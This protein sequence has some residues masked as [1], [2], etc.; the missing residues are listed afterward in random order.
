M[1]EDEEYDSLLH[2][3]TFSGPALRRWQREALDSWEDNS[4]RGVVE[5]ITGTGKSLVGVAAI[6]KTVVISGGK[7]LLVVPTRAL[8]EQ[9]S[10][11][12][13]R[14]LPTIRVG[15]LTSGFADSFAS[16]DVLIAT[17]QTACKAPPIP[18]SLGLLI[19]DEVHRY[20]SEQF[21]KVMHPR[22]QRRLGLTGT[23]ERQLDDGVE[24]YLLPYFEAV[25][26]SYGYG[27]ALSEGVVARF[28]LALVAAE[29]D[30]SEQRQYTDATERC[31]DAMK[32]LVDRY[33]YPSDWPQFFA[34]VTQQLKQE[35]CRDEE[36]DLCSKYLGGFAERRRLTAEAGSK[37]RFVEQIAGSLGQFSGSLMFTE[38]KD[39]ARR[40][41][42]LINKVTPAFPLTSDSSSTEREDK[43]RGFSAGRIKVLC[44]PR[45]L[46]EGIDVP[47]AELAVHRSR[48]QDR[49]ADDSTNGAGH[50]TQEGRSL[51]TNSDALHSGH[52]RRPRHGRT[53]IL[54]EFGAPVRL[55]RDANNREVIG[56]S[57]AVA[58]RRCRRRWWTCRRFCKL[59]YLVTSGAREFLPIRRALI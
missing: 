44:A 41:G 57:S 39:S 18:T 56:R 42:W 4:Y 7:A 14:M 3:P 23:F 5:A 16:F 31:S 54:L 6:H 38:T 26:T 50:P 19:A 43:L 21:S 37:E 34:A 32:D 20:G 9:W 53:R 35:T 46:D 25:T 52:G 8:L 33:L 28:N 58:I 2:D 27:A 10:R 59:S 48:Q 13:T 12:I 51:S 22:Y 49:E 36:S 40:L 55:Y 24:R 15:N 1:A 30:S 11:E 45:I 29:F 47:E 17:V